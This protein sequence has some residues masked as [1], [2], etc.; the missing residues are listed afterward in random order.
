MVSQVEEVLDS[1]FL[2]LIITVCWLTIH[3]GLS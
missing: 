2:S 3:G 1:H